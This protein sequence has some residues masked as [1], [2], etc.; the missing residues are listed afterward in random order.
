RS[1]VVRSRTG[2][3]CRAR[4]GRCRVRSRARGHC[5][6]RRSG[7]DRYVALATRDG[8]KH[9]ASHA[10]RGQRR[11]CERLG[12]RFHCG[13]CRRDLH[14]HRRGAGHCRSAACERQIEVIARCCGRERIASRSADRLHDARAI[15]DARSSRVHGADVVACRTTVRRSRHAFAKRGSRPMS[16]IKGRPRKARLILELLGLPRKA[17]LAAFFGK[18]IYPEVIFDHFNIAMAAKPKSLLRSLRPFALAAAL[19]ATAAY[20]DVTLLNVSYDPTRELY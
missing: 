7:R 14:G 10:T 13:R 16:T 19:F 12:A 6:A 5:S 17:A 15:A 3:S 11:T 4:S 2:R 1:A 20:A 8:A 18:H 9:S